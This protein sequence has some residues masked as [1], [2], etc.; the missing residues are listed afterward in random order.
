MLVGWKGDHDI[1]QIY[2]LSWALILEIGLVI[3]HQ[4]RQNR[5]DHWL[6]LHV[7]LGINHV[8]TGL[9]FLQSL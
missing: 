9:R 3:L 2:G 1:V 8:N 4:L 5:C 7:A 6:E